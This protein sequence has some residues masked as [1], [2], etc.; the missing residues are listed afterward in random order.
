MFWGESRWGKFVKRVIFMDEREILEKIKN[1]YG[2]RLDEQ[3]YYI[4]FNKYKNIATKTTFEAMYYT[5]YICFNGVFLSSNNSKT[6]ENNN[7]I[8][9]FFTL[10]PDKQF[11]GVEFTFKSEESFH[12]FEVCFL[13]FFKGEYKFPNHTF[14]KGKPCYRNYTTKKQ[15]TEVEYLKAVEEAFL[16]N[17]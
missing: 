8:V 17:E 1:R 15:I 2:M 13:N 6:S 9:E 3:G 16:W 12:Y 7:K 4:T 5:H 14:F 11:I 10:T